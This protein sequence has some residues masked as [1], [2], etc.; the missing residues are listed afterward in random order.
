MAAR[1]SARSSTS[2]FSPSHRWRWMVSNAA[3]IRGAGDRPARWRLDHAARQVGI[4]G[5]PRRASLPRPREWQ[6]PGRVPTFTKLDRRKSPGQCRV[7]PAAAHSGP[8]CMAALEPFLHATNHSRPEQRS[9]RILR[10]GEFLD[11]L[12]EYMDLPAYALDRRETGARAS[13][14]ASGI[15]S[16]TCRTKLCVEQLGSRPPTDFTAPRTWLTNSVRLRTNASRA[17][18]SARSR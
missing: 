10:L 18:M 16:R 15:A 3:R 12:V 8:G 17:R 11:P 13:C 1:K 9:F 2:R 6:G 14:T 5:G 4:P 7:R